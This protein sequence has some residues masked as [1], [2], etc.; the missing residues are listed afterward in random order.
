MGYW[1]EGCEYCDVF[2]FLFRDR[3]GRRDGRGGRGWVGVS[4]TLRF[5]DVEG[6]GLGSR[7]PTRSQIGFDNISLSCTPVV[8]RV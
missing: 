2:L 3:I 5:S 1:L 6:G 4:G 7:E 8:V